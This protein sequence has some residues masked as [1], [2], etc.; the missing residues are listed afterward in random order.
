MEFEY[1]LEPGILNDVCFM[2]FDFNEAGH[3]ADWEKDS[4]QRKVPRNA[5][6]ALADEVWFAQD[7]Q[8]VLISDPLQ[9]SLSA[10][11]VHVISQTRYRPSQLFL[12]DPIRGIERRISQAGEDN[13]G[14]IFDLNLAADERSFFL[15][16]FIRRVD[17]DFTG[18]EPDFANRLWSA[19]DGSEIWTHSDAAEIT[20]AVPQKRKLLVHFRQ[21]L[22]QRPQ[23][24]YWQDNSDFSEDI[25]GSVDPSGNG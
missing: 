24:H 11:K 18:F 22:A 2:L 21:E 12:W 1:G 8:R 16:K 25:D 10:L 3:P 13:L 9:R 6:G 15:F 23:L 14:P 7:A 19:E 5:A 4:H 17:G 20:S